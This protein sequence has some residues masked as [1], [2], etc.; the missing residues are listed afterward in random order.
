MALINEQTR[1]FA[2]AKLPR[3]GTRARVR[4]RI[5]SKLLANDHSKLSCARNRSN[6]I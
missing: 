1:L 3:M 5:I 4:V 6:G 2:Y